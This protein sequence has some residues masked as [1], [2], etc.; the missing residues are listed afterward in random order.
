MERSKDLEE[1]VRAM[2]AAMGSNDFAAFEGRL[3]RRPETRMIGTDPAEWWTGYDRVAEVTQIQLKELEG[4]RAV[5][6]E[7]EAFVEG[8][9]GWFADQPRWVMTD[10]TEIA[11]RFTGVFHRE[12][13]D[14]KLVQAHA[15]IGVPNQDVVGFSLTT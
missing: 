8:D 9:V 1:A 12:N 14:W 11:L 7:L 5:P 3:S 10:G 13:G 15:S 6:G 2:Y 4:M